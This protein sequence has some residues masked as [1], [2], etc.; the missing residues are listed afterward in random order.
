MRG[1]GWKAKETV[2]GLEKK[3]EEA[4]KPGE[5]GFGQIK[6]VSGAGQGTASSCWRSE[7][8][9][10]EAGRI[11]LVVRASPWAGRGQGHRGRVRRS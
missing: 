5:G 1:C 6:Q 8:G 2:A 3:E 7:V 10:S 4:E 9:S 11:A